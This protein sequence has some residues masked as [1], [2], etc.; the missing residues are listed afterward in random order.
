MKATY[1]F[2]PVK[3][4]RTSKPITT[5][6]FHRCSVLALVLDVEIF[7]NKHK[8]LLTDPSFLHHLLPDK[9]INSIVITDSRN[10]RLSVCCGIRGSS[11]VL[12]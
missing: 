10:S 1:H 7:Q 5:Q 9:V 4:T 8:V 11:T 2:N 12:N 6:M 3:G